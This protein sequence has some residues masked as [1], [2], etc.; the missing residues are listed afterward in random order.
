MTRTSTRGNR[1]D[2]EV[3]PAANSG[4]V[5]IPQFLQPAPPPPRRQDSLDPLRTT[6]PPTQETRGEHPG[7]EDEDEDEDFSAD[8]MAE[9]PPADSSTPAST[10]APAPRL[11]PL[12]TEQQISAARGIVRTGLMG[13]TALA[14]RKLRAHQDD[15]RFLM[16]ED[17]LDDVSAPFSRILARR[18]PIPGGEG[19]DASDMADLVEGVVALLAYSMRQLF[20]GPAPM[21]TGVEYAPETTQQIPPAGPGA[22][23]N[24]FAYQAG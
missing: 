14:N 8:A 9:G 5:P 6:V 20:A 17:E 24:P 22:T 11:R 1:E 3:A 10:K 7:D 15:R 4:G 18:T 12:V 23:S 21:P 16:T 19:G 2:D 13:A